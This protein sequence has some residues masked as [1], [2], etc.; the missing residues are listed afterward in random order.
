[1]SSVQGLGWRIVNLIDV[2]ACRQLSLLRLSTYYTSG[3]SLRQAR[4]LPMDILVCGA[5][6]INF[7][8]IA[9]HRRQSQNL[10]RL[11]KPGFASIT[12]YF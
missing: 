6:V 7:S 2:A 9:D 11:S 10:L 1:M 5:Y 8:L 12:F 3:S 4:F